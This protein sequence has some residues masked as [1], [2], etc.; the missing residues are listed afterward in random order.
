MILIIIASIFILL[1]VISIVGIV[2]FNASVEKEKVLLFNTSREID[3]KITQKDLDD[4]PDLMKNYLS[5]VKIVGKPKYCN[6]IFTQ[7]GEIRTGS[8]KKWLPFSATQYMS[9]NN[10]GFIWKAKALPMLIRD[11]Y[12][13]DTGEVK[14]SLLGLKDV[15]L[16]TGQKVDQ[17][18]LGRCLGE[19][20]WFPIGFLDPDIS[21]EPIDDR[22]VKATIT[23]KNN[24]LDGFFIFDQNGM[25]DHFKTKRYRDTELENFIGEVGKYQDRNELLIP[26]TMTAA[27][28][29]KKGKLN[30]FK[31][32]IVDYKLVSATC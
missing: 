7:K 8:K 18:S 2:S 30:Y 27:W 6:V 17:S 26:D 5:K 16:F 10:S 25:I 11:R 9:S 19:L 31:A 15:V 29:L 24:T 23:K 1:I 4:F 28:N 22:T 21:W 3:I 12:T 20:I 14:V 32:S 13:N